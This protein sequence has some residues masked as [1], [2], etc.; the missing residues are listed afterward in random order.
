MRR[1]MA[2]NDR[3]IT[4]NRNFLE[5][6]GVLGTMKQLEFTLFLVLCGAAVTATAGDPRPNSAPKIESATQG[7]EWRRT[8]PELTI[9]PGP[10][11]ARVGAEAL[12]AHASAATLEEAID[13]CVLQDMALVGTAGASVAVAVDGELFYQMGYGVKHRTQGGAVDADTY[14]RIGSVTKMLTAAAVMQQVEAGTVALDDPVTTHVPEFEVDGAYPADRITIRHL[15]THSSG[16]PD[17]GF[18]L[19]G[20]LGNQAL[21]TWAAD[22]DEVLLHAPPGVFWNDSNP[23]FNLAGLVAERASGIPYRD[24]MTTSVFGAAGMT[25][26]TFDPDE[27]MADGNYTFGHL[28]YA[29]GTELI[30]PPDDYDNW[31]YQPAGYAF[32]TAGDLVRFA[33]TLIDG[34]GSMLS[35]AS[36]HAMQGWQVDLDLVPGFGY[37]F[38]I[39]VEPLGDLVIRQHGGNIPGWGAFLL[40]ETDSRF[41]VA[42]LANSFNSLSGAAYCIADAALEPAAGPEIPDST[43]PSTFDKYEGTWDFTYQENYPLVGEIIGANEDGVT[44]FLDDPVGPFDGWYELVHIGYGVFLADLDENGIPDADFTFIG[45]GSP[46]RANWLRSRILVGSPRRGPRRGGPRLP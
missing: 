32:S 33:L 29:G 4:T 6:W 17:L 25:R 18:N 7:A 5:G 16:F 13:L 22:Q 30:Y 45:R 26:S 21:S 20:P 11:P 41:A 24:Y 36:C 31:V 23:N 37:G 43:D 14:F 19:Q 27:V 1:M 12:K 10:V 8:N 40:W 46:E 28:L 35:P 38:G 42:V 44:L 15:L 39:F 3:S 2:V 34:G 9:G